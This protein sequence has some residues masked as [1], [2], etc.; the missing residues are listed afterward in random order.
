VS[1]HCT[2]IEDFFRP[3]VTSGFSKTKLNKKFR[4]AYLDQ[5]HSAKV[6]SV[7][8]EGCQQ[9]DA[10]FTKSSNLVLVVK[11]A[12]CLPLFF[13]SSQLGVVGMVHMGWRSAKAGILDNIPY[14]LSSFKAA[15]GV[16]LRRCCYEVGKEFLNHSGL[17]SHLKERDSKYY[18]NPLSFAKTKLIERGLRQENFLDLDICSLCSGD[19]F[20]S[21]RRDKTSSRTLSFI[22][23]I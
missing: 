3:E 14:D 12:D 19:G 11:T 20:P 5:I 13:S 16:G 23:K 21:F 9:G 17:A 4:V 22:L 15:A 1:P 8:K 2:L 7:D 10:L 18:F 6:F